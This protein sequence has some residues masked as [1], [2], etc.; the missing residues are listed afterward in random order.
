LT[1]KLARAEAVEQFGAAV[2]AFVHHLRPWP[3]SSAER[4]KAMAQAKRTKSNK[5]VAGAGTPAAVTLHIRN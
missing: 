2:R 5:L 4:R 3:F 1:N